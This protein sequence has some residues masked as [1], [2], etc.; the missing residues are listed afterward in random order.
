[1]LLIVLSLMTLSQAPSQAPWGP[2]ARCTLNPAKPAGL[3]PGAYAALQS[4]QLV[5]RIT[6]G[7]NNTS[8]ARNVHQTDVT[9][10]GK[11]YTGAVDISVRCLTEA[12]IKTLLGR[13]AGVGFAGWYR[14]GGQDGWTG[15]NHIHAVWAGV[16]LKPVLQQQVE[17][18][19]SGGNGLFSSQAYLF[20]Q[21]SQTMKD[22]VQRLY[23][24]TN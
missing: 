6:Q 8:E 4:L 12:Q 16:R 3:H 5:H 14:K 20:W 11:P 13:L 1:M 18:W 21:P 24:T 15:P 10:G 17:S 9:V 19:L 23:R 2:Q 22:T 7:L